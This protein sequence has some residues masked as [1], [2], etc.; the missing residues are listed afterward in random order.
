MTSLERD[1]G[2]GEPSVSPQGAAESP[3]SPQGTAESPAS[4]QGAAESPAS[5]QGAAESPASPQGA[6]ELPAS[7][8]VS[9][10]VADLA[11]FW[12]AL[13]VVVF[14]F[15]VLWIV[16]SWSKYSTRYAQSS[17]VWRVGGTHLIEITLIPQDVH[18]LACS[19]DNEF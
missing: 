11:V 3:A 18:N 15:A 9:A 14:I 17:D 16:V 10:F 19:S 7:P 13:S 6:A 8:R 4:P 5:P 12:R 2:V 1:P